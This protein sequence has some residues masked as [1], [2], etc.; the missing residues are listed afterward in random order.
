MCPHITLQCSG[1]PDS[2]GH[3]E[4]HGRD[5]VFSPILNEMKQGRWSNTH[6]DCARCYIESALS[7]ATLVTKHH[8][9]WVDR[10]I[11]CVF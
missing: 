11:L 6:V 7:T 8:K 5:G 1:R 9:Y 10:M 4:E 2:H 3:L